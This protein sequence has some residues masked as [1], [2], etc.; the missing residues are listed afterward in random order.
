MAE[1]KTG[2][3]KSNCYCAIETAYGRQKETLKGTS[4]LGDGKAATEVE[5]QTSSIK[6]PENLRKGIQREHL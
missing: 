1:S 6:E 4:G 2:T 5:T 3:K